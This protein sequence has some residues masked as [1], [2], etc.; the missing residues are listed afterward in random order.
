[1]HTA[2]YTC[3]HGGG[4]LKGEDMG[5]SNESLSERVPHWGMVIDLFKCIG[6]D[7][8]TISCKAE[9]RTPPGIT[10]NVVL[11][12]EV[13][14]YPNMRVHMTPR[15][16]MQCQDAPCVEACPVKASYLGEDGIVVI[17]ADRCI[18]CRYCIAACPYGARSVDEG[19]S[20]IAEM[21]AADQVVV[22]EYGVERS[23]SA[24]KRNL[25]GSVRKCTFCSHRIAH[26]E[27]PACCETCLGDARVFGD[28]NDPDSVVSK[29]ASSSRASLL[30]EELGTNPSVYYLR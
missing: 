14:V 20:Y 18:G 26:G 10:Y 9:N 3:F 7:A 21:Q 6:C 13:G 23:G 30:K 8:C 2:F 27:V 22:P 24:E 11:E 19:M 29:L 25:Q 1:M 28:L 12:E 5:A 15:P 16:C 4:Q 17:D